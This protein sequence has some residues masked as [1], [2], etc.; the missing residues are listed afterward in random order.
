MWGDLRLDAAEPPARGRGRLI[1]GGLLAAVASAGVAAWLGV[2]SDQYSLWERGPKRT[3]LTGAPAGAPP[4]S[5]GAQ[6]DEEQVRRAYLQ[7]QDV[8]A[9]GGAAALVRFSSTCAQSLKSNPGI[10][11][12]CLAFDL[13]SEVLAPQAAGA[14]EVRRLTLARAALPASGDPALRIAQVRG[15]MRTVS[16]RSEPAAIGAP[17]ERVRTAEPAE[18]PASAKPA[19]AKVAAAPAGA[20]PARVRTAAVRTS[21]RP[22][23][24]KASTSCRQRPTAAQRRACFRA[25]ARRAELRQRSRPAA[26]RTPTNRSLLD[27][28]EADLRGDT[29]V[30]VPPLEEPPY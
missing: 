1:L 2:A 16:R 7:F 8:Y 3:V 29:G 14:A 30:T 28:L 6:A 18:R 21:K 11:D 10:L 20:R 4:R 19:R 12:Y 25:S 15:L 23:L 22:V 13:F 26:H 9:E 17:S 27:R 24:S 5:P